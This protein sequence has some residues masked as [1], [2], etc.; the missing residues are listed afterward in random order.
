VGL[1]VA[2]RLF[3]KHKSIEEVILSL[4]KNKAFKDR[5]PDSYLEAVKRVQALFFF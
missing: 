3:Q 1:K 4:Q 5:V 2:L